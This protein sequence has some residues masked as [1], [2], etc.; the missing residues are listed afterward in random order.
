L[1]KLFRKNLGKFFIKERRLMMHEEWVVLLEFPM[2]EISNFGNIINRATGRLVAKSTTRQNVVKVALINGRGRFT[3][4]VAVM[5]GHIFVPNHSDLFNTIIHL[6]GDLSNCEAT[7]LMWRPRWFTYQYH[8]QFTAQREICID[9]LGLMGPIYEKATN[10]QYA[11]VYEAAISNGLLIRD[12][13]HRTND[14]DI[15]NKQ[16]WPTRQI[17]EFED[18]RG[19]DF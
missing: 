15:H 7:N 9:D 2:Y 3:R 10:L 19:L 11:N 17:F 13:F 8:R 1:E 6:D 12:I 14:P 4:S 16:V 18:Q 5:V